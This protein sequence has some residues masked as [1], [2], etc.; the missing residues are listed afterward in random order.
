MGVSGAMWREMAHQGDEAEMGTAKLFD[1]A[2]ELRLLGSRQELLQGTV[3][4]QGGRIG[5]VASLFD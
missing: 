5:M 3:Q 2:E 1:R 4:I